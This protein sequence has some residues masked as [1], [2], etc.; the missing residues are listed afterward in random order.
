[1]TA[2][3]APAA[4]P[5]APPG[6]GDRLSLSICYDQHGY[7]WFT[8]TDLTQHVTRT[9]TEPVPSVVYDGAGLLGEADGVTSPP[10]E[11]R[12]WRFTSH[13]TTYGG[14]RGPILG[15][16]TTSPVIA[17]TIGTTSGPVV[18][19]PYCLWNGGQNFGVWPRRPY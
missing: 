1:M 8:V 18:Q 13:V 15:P 17:T 2:S 19:S 12:Q 10:A 16:W 6:Y 3:S 7:D 9:V 11:T 14:D 5:S 4:A